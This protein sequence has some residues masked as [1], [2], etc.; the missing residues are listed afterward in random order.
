MTISS[1]IRIAGPFIGTGTA[2]SFA[3]YFKVFSAADL[4]VVRLT[5]SSAAETVLSLT[6]DYTVVLNSNQNTNPGGTVTLVS[7][8]LAAGYHL[9]ITST[10]ANV[11]PTDLTNQ[12][13]FYP[14]VI[15]DSLDRATIQIQQ[16]D[17]QVARSIIGPVSDGQSLDMELPSA[18]D[19]SGKYL[20]FNAVGEPIAS[21]GT[22]ADTG[23][24]TDLA[25]STVSSA[26][27]GLV[28]FRHSSASSTAR[29][30]LARL[31][32]TINVKDF[33]AIG[34]GVA[35]D[36]S[37]IQAALDAIPN[38]G[39]IL[40]FPAGSYRVTTTL[41]LP[42]MSSG[43][44]LRPVLIRGESN[45]TDGSTGSYITHTSTTQALF[46]GRGASGIGTAKGV[47]GIRNMQLY[48]AYVYGTGSTV[49]SIGLNLYDCA[50]INL[51]QV[52]FHGFKYGLQTEGNLYYSVIDGCA[53]RRC[54]I[55]WYHVGGPVNGTTISRC[56]WGLMDSHCVSVDYFA[57]SCQFTG[58]WFEAATSD[59]I[60]A[61]Y[62][63]RLCIRDSYFEYAGTGYAVQLT[64][65]SAAREVL[66][67]FD[68]N[69]V[70]C[71]SSADAVI[72]L[73]NAATSVLFVCH[74]NDLRCDIK[75]T[76]SVTSLIR[77]AT[78]STS[79]RPLFGEVVFGD[80]GGSTLKSVPY[81]SDTNNVSKYAYGQVQFPPTQNESADATTLDDYYEG[82]ATL[83]ATG[84]TTTITTPCVYAKIGKVVTLSI[85]AFNGTSNATTLTLT[86]L[87]ARLIPLSTREN[88]TG[89]RDSGNWVVGRMVITTAGVIEFYVNSGTAFTASGA[90][91][92]NGLNVSYV[93]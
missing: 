87:P 63:G 57:E 36:T 3:F 4:E 34:D 53:F 77:N 30:V 59:L 14:E 16:L 49:T 9:T 56:R 89:V 85:S 88:A 22:G 10:I 68:S 46:Q 6:S 74:V 65:E 38:S 37:A 66:F 48:G 28:G 7:G 71:D 69:Y 75:T 78:G 25:N 1:P 90:K 15:T 43:T 29:T 82:T 24:R 61:R 60:R 13:G 5:V 92:I 55:G 76:S 51:E 19:R 27:A 12:G 70:S 93:I 32:D 45:S 50:G 62:G 31:R 20:A 80:D 41:I 8:A 84:F 11:Q 39:A 44:S 54:D 26:G 67:S 52:M 33:G 2:S 40:L 35:D 86:G 83:T 42:T 47:I 79:T 21:T 91:A 72:R 17:D 64:R 58:C 18:A 23:L 81:T 73:E